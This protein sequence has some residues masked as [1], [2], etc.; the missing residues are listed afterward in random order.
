MKTKP[1]FLLAPGAGAPSTHPRM[2][3]FADLLGD[4]GCVRA[5]D[6][7]YMLRGAKRPDP[8]PRL[9]EA[10]RD[11]LA[12]A[13]RITGA[14]IV[15]VGKSMGGR[16][17]CHLSLAEPAPAVI[18][19]GYPLVSASNPANVRDAVLLDMSAPVLFVQGTRDPMC[20]LDLLG[21]TRARMHTIHEAHVVEGGDHSLLVSKTSLK[22]R[23]LTQEQS[24]QAILAAIAQFLRRVL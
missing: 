2:R 20:P 23:A 4:L 16:V 22:A 17:G 8:L 19:L 10:H 9:I 13:R 1:V 21:S 7:P 18:C 15:L 11:A 24:D 5:F 14:P 6:Y 3:V 12:Q